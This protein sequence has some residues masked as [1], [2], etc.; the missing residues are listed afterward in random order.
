MARVFENPATA[1]LAQLKRDIGA[2][3]S[4]VAWN[5]SFEKG[6]NEEMARMEPECADFLKAINDRFFDLMLIF[7]FKRQIYVKSEFQKSASL[8]KVLPV[9]C[10][11][12]S[13]KSLAIQEGGKAAASWPVLTGGEITEKEKARLAEDML[14]YCKR[15]TEAMVGILERLEK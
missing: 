6:C 15:D 3:G 11:E 8:K 12:L 13:Y 7:K 9:I 4:I 2:N 14:A 10:P 1:L 5:A